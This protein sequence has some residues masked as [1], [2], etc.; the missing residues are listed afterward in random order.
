MN[1]PHFIAKRISI[2]G[3]RTFTSV[4]VRIAVAAIA[5]SLAVMIISSAII[6]GFKN[7][8]TEK[9][10]AFWGDIH[11]N[12][13]GINRTF[14]EIP[15][16]D[17]RQIAEEI[18]Q[19]KGLE[20]VEDRYLLGM[21][22]GGI[23][24]NASTKGGVKSVQCTVMIQGLIRTRKDFNGIILKGIGDDFDWSRLN[25]FIVE[26]EAFTPG[27]SIDDGLLLSKSMAN[28]MEL[29]TG[30]PVI[31]SFIKDQNHLRRRF[32]VKGIFNTGL[33]EYDSKMGLAD[34]RKVR[35]VMGWK[36]H[37]AGSIEVVLDHPHDAEFFTEY[38][39]Y[40]VLPGHLFAMSIRQKF[41]SIFEWLK[42]QEIN[43]KI[44]LALMVVVGII[45]MLTVLMILIL[46]RSR[47]IGILK[48]LGSTNGLIRKI[49]LYNAC[50]IIVLGMLLGNFLGL[51]FCYFQ[52]KY[53]WITLDEASYY[54]S[55]APVEVN[56]VFLGFL[57]LA[58]FLLILSV[59]II[60]TWLISYIHPVKVLR[61]E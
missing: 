19:L 51:A 30:D 53:Q 15:I 6:T 1:L 34:I 57:N 29:K 21:R 22:L 3:H 54:L 27:D 24:R 12:D 28:K 16:N 8:I 61:F 40:D 31:I 38:I 44:I 26:G 60:P 13:A 10:I 18:E 20:F 25:R 50:Y 4:I 52:K 5:L 17:Y 2:S 14:E 58:T 7:E 32:T 55:V 41:P 42:L 48:A 37:Q 36:E 9:V 49:F 35:E 39:Y 59:M 43:E 56:F 23:Q 46:E 45:N 47:M 33:E 11:I